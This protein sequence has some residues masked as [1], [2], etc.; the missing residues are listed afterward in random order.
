M[1]RRGRVIFFSSLPDPFKSFPFKETNPFTA[2]ESRKKT[3][4][5]P[6]YKKEGVLGLTLSLVV[7]RMSKFCGKRRE[8]RT[9]K[10]KGKKELNGSHY[11]HICL[12]WK[13]GITENSFI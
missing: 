2:A 13:V 9:K 1:A 5:L 3:Q 4:G 6:L 10:S 8:G 7:G 11:L 12:G